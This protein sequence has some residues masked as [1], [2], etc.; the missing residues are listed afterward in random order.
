MQIKPSVFFILC[1]IS[2]IIFLIS[3]VLI[4][5]YEIEYSKF[6]D[7][8]KYLLNGEKS[9]IDPLTWMVIVDLRFPRL[10]CTFIIGA[11]LAVSGAC[12]QGLFRNP[13]VEPS[14][15]GVSAG[16]ATFVV[17]FLVLG[18]SIIEKYQILSNISSYLV[19]IIAFSGS[20]FT[21][22][23]V[24]FLATINGRTSIGS[25]L[26]SGIAI[27]AFCGALMGMVLY[28][29]NDNQ[30]RSI[31]F[32]NLGSFSNIGWFE[33][34]CLF[35]FFIFGIYF[36]YKLHSELNILALGE[37]QAISLGIHVEKLTKKIIYLSCLTVGA[38]VS[39]TGIIGFV[40]LI[41]PHLTRF[42]LGP[43]F[44]L[45]IPGSAFLGGLLLIVSDIGARSMIQGAELPIGSITALL[46]G[47]FFLYQIFKSSQEL[48]L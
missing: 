35:P 27:N 43:N 46:G 18:S 38:C 37:D 12:M 16:A 24:V 4:G 26:L 22:K 28:F 20:L 6:L 41:I 5:Q 34:Y 7:I 13:L 48:N 31:T 19:P 1:F 40:G 9:Q 30:L 8:L 47:P 2:L 14:L 33:V 36:F 44:K 21:V 3:G 29:A 23:I 15:L 39:F 25:L 17:I 45:L 32:W 42:I 11:L 10:I